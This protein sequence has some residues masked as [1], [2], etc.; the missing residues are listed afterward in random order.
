MLDDRLRPVDSNIYLLFRA[1]REVVQLTLVQV[2]LAELAI[3]LV[4]LYV[5]LQADKAL[6]VGVHPIQDLSKDLGRGLDCGCAEKKEYRH[7]REYKS[8][9]FIHKNFH[10]LTKKLEPSSGSNLL[11]LI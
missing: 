6:V 2:V 3:Q 4:H 5:A 11:S 9:I 7:R 10:S 1:S 8:Q